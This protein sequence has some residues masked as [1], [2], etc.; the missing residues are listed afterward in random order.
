MVTI[1][2]KKLRNEIGI[3][4]ARQYISAYYA[5]WRIAA[6]KMTD[7]FPSVQQL[8]LYLANEQ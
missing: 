4:Q 6:M 3:F 5:Y 8:P 7:S 1:E 2:A